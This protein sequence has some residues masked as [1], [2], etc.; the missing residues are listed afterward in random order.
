MW[1]ASFTLQVYQC[2]SRLINIASLQIR[3]FPVLLACSQTAEI[4]VQGGRM[5]LSCSFS[6]HALISPFPDIHFAAF[7]R[8]LIDET[9]LFI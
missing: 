2:G 9:I 4:W 8:N 7:P 5:S 6:L 1:L 3:K